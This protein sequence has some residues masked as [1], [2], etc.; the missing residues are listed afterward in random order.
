MMKWLSRLGLGLLLLMAL[1]IALLFSLYLP[2]TEKVFVTG[3]EVKRTDV[4]P[5]DTTDA[6]TRD[7]R[8]IQTKLAKSGETKVFRNEDTRWGWPPYFKFNS[9]DLSGEAI[10]IAQKQPDAVVLV[11]YY[12]WHSNIFGLFPNLVSL[13]VVPASYEHFPLFNVVFVSAFCLG[14]L[15]LIF[16]V[17]GRIKRRREASAAKAQAAAGAPAPQPEAGGGPT[18]AE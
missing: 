14:C 11:T 7:V 16:G 9:T 13:Q 5:D 4:T 8:Y 6:R 1:M 15:I 17:R 3:S 2:R 10:S 18:S 12:G